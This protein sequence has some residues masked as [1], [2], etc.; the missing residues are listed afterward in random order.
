LDVNG[1]GLDDIY[2]VSHDILEVN[3]YYKNLMADLLLLKPLF[4]KMILLWRKMLL[5][6]SSMQMG[7]DRKT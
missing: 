4:L 5:H 2:P 1:D 7:M 3:Y 6:S